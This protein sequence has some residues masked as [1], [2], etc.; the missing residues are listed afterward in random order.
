[1]V[2]RAANVE[3]LVKASTIGARA[4]SPL[5]PFDSHGRSEEHLR[6]SGVP[7]VVLESGFY[8]T[9]LLA[10]AEPIRAQG[11][12]PAPA[13]DGRIAMIDP[14]DVGAVGAA[15]LCGGGRDG[16]GTRPHRPRRPRLR[17]VRPRP[18]RG[19]RPRRSDVVTARPLREPPKR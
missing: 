8:M 16:H 3:L 2:D 5:P 9:N 15:V 10:A 19:V 18:R 13:G 7:Y 1:V 6:R 17:R 14:R 4:G 11:I 12:L